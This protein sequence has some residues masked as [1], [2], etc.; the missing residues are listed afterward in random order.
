MRC[1]KLT[2]VV[3]TIVVFVAAVSACAQ[4]SAYV[5]NT[6]SNS[7]SVIDTA[8]FAVT[9]TITVGTNP[10][11]VA[12][13]PD[14]T[15]AYV[16][17]YGS[18]SV[19]V[20]DT[21][22]NSV[23]TTVAVGANPYGVA[24]S[25]D[26]TRA[27]VSNGVSGTVSV[28]DTGSNAVIATV[29]VA[30]G[31]SHLREVA[32]SP[33]GSR[34]Y[35][36]SQA[37]G[38][39]SV[40]DT[41]TN[42]VVA[43]VAVGLE[44][45]GVV[46]T[47]DGA[48]AYV[49]VGQNQHE[50]FFVSVINTASNTVT[51][52][53]PVGGAPTLLAITRDGTRVYVPNH[54]SGTVSVIDTASN[55][56]IAT[57]AVG[58][59]PYAVAISA[60][61][62]RAYVADADSNSVWVIDVLSNTVVTSVGVG[63][64]PD[65]VALAPLGPKCAPPPSGLVAWWPGD[66]NANDTIG[67][68]NG[69][70]LNGTTFA[71]GRVRQSFSF[72]GVDDLVETPTKNWGFSTTATVTGWVRTTKT[73]AQGVFSLAHDF[74]EDEMLLYISDGHIVVFNHK[75]PGNYTGRMSSSVV[76][77]GEWVF[78]AGVFDG[79][80]SASNLRIFVNG[81]EE[82][83]TAF[84]AGSPSD[85][86]D[87]TPRSVRLGRRTTA[88]ATEIF[89]GEIDEVQL[90]NRA[91]TSG[92]VAAI[93]HAGSA[94]VCTTNRPPVADAGASQT[95][96]CSSHSGTPVTLDGSASSDPDNDI[97]TFRWTDAG[98]NVIGNTAMVNVAALLGPSTYTL[99]VTDPSGLSATAT[100][101]V[102]VV[103][104]TPPLL[105]LSTNSIVV[106][107]PTASATG[108][109]ASLAGIASASDICDPSPTITNNAPA[110]FPIGTTTVTFTATDHSGNSSQQQLTVRVLFNLNGYFSPLLNDGQAVFKAGRT[111]P[112]KF[113][114]TA[115]DGSIV[116]NA[117]ANIQVYKVLNTPTGTVDMTV[118]TF[119]SGSSNSGTLFRYDASSGQYIYNLSTQGYGVG[120]Y[121]IRTTLNDGTTHDVQFSLK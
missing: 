21:T 102:T 77:T 3:F 1:T 60:D 61:G 23:V 29:T 95:V 50:P 89:E 108:T 85:I 18:A 6:S 40:I 87:T 90:Y 45:V 44:P 10:Y 41:A 98:N 62:T 13:T 72:D 22:N 30:G 80:G 84:S 83:G 7:V 24:I 86:V 81:V 64:Q 31:N 120:T 121:L 73:G 97:L 28:I 113:Q 74:L 32:I 91:L 16:A 107:L 52:T 82:T 70:L 66:G 56:V 109:A 68:N 75:S 14:G 114:L 19:S 8:S 15:R 106:T 63:V 26:G 46:I 17:N 92:E 104:T 79:G 116:S 58:V 111:I 112:V 110:V 33:D 49:T 105:T 94:G 57:V 103:D 67:G 47:P 37:N 38:T 59:G 4:N 55:T 42:T 20:I 101:H 119:A 88:V 25:P 99:K 78:V 71:A 54:L 76:N 96:E 48:H 34:V 2:V 65:G 9:S 53:I 12:I 100:T 51:A 43:T 5:S 117:I 36:A 35:V 115:A 69:T 27:Y 118:D 11:G 39:V 93:F